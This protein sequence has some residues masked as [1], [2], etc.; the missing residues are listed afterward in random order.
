MRKNDKAYRTDLS[1][2]ICIPVY[3]SDIAALIR[4]LTIQIQNSDLPIEIYALDDGS[5]HDIKEKNRKIQSPYFHYGELST[6]IGRAQIRNLLGQ[7]AQGQY[8]LFLDNDVKIQSEL[9]LNNYL[10][11]IKNGF[12]AVVCGS[13][14]YPTSPISPKHTLH[15]KYGTRVIGRMHT[16]KAKTLI[17]MN[18][19][20]RKDILEQFQ[21]YSRLNSYGHE[22]TLM[23]YEI[24]KNKLDM[25]FIDNAVY[26]ADLDENLTYLQKNESAI[27]NL[28]F[29]YQDPTTSASVSN[30]PLIHTYF[31][32]RK[33]QLVGICNKIYTIY[34]NKIRTNLLSGNP[35]MSYFKLYKLGELLRILKN[36]RII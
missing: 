33:W 9:F 11:E 19:L 5:T 35:S 7:C 23:G 25:R 16:R 20:I 8:C 6:N 36:N 22:D 34:R 4:Q 12:P 30:T 10:A 28:A 15:W 18:F 3:N 24:E 31:L 32:L 13:T 27:H 17:S 1:I 14:T 26:H 29:L 21:F 2:S